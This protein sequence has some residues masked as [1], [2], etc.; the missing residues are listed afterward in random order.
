M[1]SLRKKSPTRITSPVASSAAAVTPRLNQHREDMENA[2]P[3]VLV[4]SPAVRY[5][6]HERMEIEEFVR[7]LKEI[8]YVER[9]V[10]SAKI[11]LALKSDFNIFDAFKLYDTRG[12]GSI[13]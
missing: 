12:A 4:M 10:E 1:P 11:E 6:P 13:S 2:K 5:S 3:A 7:V 8:I 9:E